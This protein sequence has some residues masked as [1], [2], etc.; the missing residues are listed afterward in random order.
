ML[1]SWR[2]NA[3]LRSGSLPNSRC[4]SWL[5]YP[6]PFI[7]GKETTLAAL[8]MPANRLDAAWRLPE[9]ILVRLERRTNFERILKKPFAL[10]RANTG[11]ACMPLTL[12]KPAPAGN[13]TLSRQKGFVT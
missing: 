8:R 3:L 6:C 4:Q 1:M 5:V 2:R 13:V 9:V 11:L 12:N 10:F 7:A